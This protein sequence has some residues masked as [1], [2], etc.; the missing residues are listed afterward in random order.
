MNKRGKTVRTFVCPPL[1]PR[2]GVVRFGVPARFVSRASEAKA[3][4]NAAAVALA[5]A[6]KAA[7]T[8][9]PM[10]RTSPPPA[11]VTIGSGAGKASPEDK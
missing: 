7:A 8:K 6:K 1:H 10:A 5:V 2:G 11:S 9:S 4:A 3:N